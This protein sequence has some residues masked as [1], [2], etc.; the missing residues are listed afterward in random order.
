MEPLTRRLPASRSPSPRSTTRPSQP[1][2]AR[3][4]QNV[5]VGGTVTCADVD[6]STWRSDRDGP[7]RG[8][9]APF[10]AASGAF[11]YSRCGRHGGDSFTVTP[12]TARPIPRPSWTSRSERRPVAGTQSVTT[13]ED[14]A[15]AITWPAL[16]STWTRRRTRCGQPAHGT[17]PHGPPHLCRT[18]TT[19]ARTSFTF[20]VYDGTVPLQGCHHPSPSPP[21]TTPRSR[22][23]DGLR[24]TR[25]RPRSR[26]WPTTT[27]PRL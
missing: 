22:R 17:S 11:T 3:Y 9:A 20:T 19:T 18:P 5:P 14:T 6:G 13:G 2:R 1:S 15:T 8:T 25:R 12:T 7:G 4:E 16:T 21:S 26:S 10:N 27:V 24:S 23:T